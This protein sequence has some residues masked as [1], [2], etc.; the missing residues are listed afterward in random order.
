M[1]QWLAFIPIWVF[2][3]WVAWRLRL[4]DQRCE[5]VE[6]LWAEMVKWAMEQK[7]KGGE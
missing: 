1:S 2:M 7:Q 6:R 3:L 4:C 5:R